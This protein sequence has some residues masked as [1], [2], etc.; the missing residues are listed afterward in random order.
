MP[1][2]TFFFESA[3]SKLTKHADLLFH[4]DHQAN[5][6]EK[7]LAISLGFRDVFMFYDAYADSV[8]VKVG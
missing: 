8:N 7:Y 2:F 5:I 1:S 6:S 3:I 4:F